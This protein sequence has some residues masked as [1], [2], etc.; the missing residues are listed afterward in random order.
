[1]SQGNKNVNPYWGFNIGTADWH[2]HAFPTDLSS[3]HCQSSPCL[4]TFILNLPK[5]QSASTLLHDL[6]QSHYA[7]KK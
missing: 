3:R 1:M 2:S 5:P 7:G 4:I 6:E